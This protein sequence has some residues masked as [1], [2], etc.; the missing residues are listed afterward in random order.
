M[1]ARLVPYYSSGEYAVDSIC[2]IPPDATLIQTGRSMGRGVTP[3][4]G[5]EGSFTDLDDLRATLAKIKKTLALDPLKLPLYQVYVDTQLALLKKEFSL[6][7]TGFSTTYWDN[8]NKTLESETGKDH[9]INGCGHLPYA[10]ALQEYLQSEVFELWS[11]KLGVTE[12]MIFTRVKSRLLN[13][14]GPFSKVSALIGAM[15]NVPVSFESRMPGLFQEGIQKEASARYYDSGDL[16]FPLGYL[17]DSP[18]GGHLMLC[19]IVKPLSS[20]SGVKIELYN[21]LI[22]QTERVSQA[23]HSVFSI[24]TVLELHTKRKFKEILEDI[25]TFLPLQ[26]PALMNKKIQHLFGGGSLEESK[27]K[28]QKLT[29][30]IFYGRLGVGAEVMNKNQ[31]SVLDT[32]ELLE[33]RHCVPVAFRM[34]LYQLIKEC[35]TDYAYKETEHSTLKDLG[36]ELMFEFTNF[37]TLKV[38]D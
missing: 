36:K 31:A 25:Y 14:L 7:S 15:K 33:G 1:S 27:M 20:R 23:A 16:L 34:L 17:L 2:C 5:L 12:N 37:L 13:L 9:S 29:S 22:S 3:M 11:S 28:V 21:P 30:E 10:I 35:A 32:C 8:L 6:L 4:V 24:P 18:V 26:L 38:R 19:R